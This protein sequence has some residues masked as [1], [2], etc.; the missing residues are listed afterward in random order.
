MKFTVF[1][2]SRP[3]GFQVP[4][5]EDMGV[6]PEHHTVNRILARNDPTKAHYKMA[7]EVQIE[8]DLPIEQQLDKVF[9]LTN[10]IDHDWTHNPEIIWHA[11]RVRSTSVGDVI[12]DSRG[13]RHF[14][15]S[16][17]FKVF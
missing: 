11:D 8:D 5:E 17:G 13:A 16:F 4:L 14:I 3:Q 9:E 1:H 15:D 10:H 2:F 6:R 7:A 12:L